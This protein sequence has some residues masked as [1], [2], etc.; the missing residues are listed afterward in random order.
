ML[1]MFTPGEV[2]V[3]TGLSTGMQLDWRKRGYLPV[4]KGRHA[5]FNAFDI[6]RLMVMKM[7]SDRGVG[8]ADTRL[9]ADICAT[10]ILYAALCERTAYR[11]D[12]DLQELKAQRTDLQ[13]ISRRVIHD[14]TG[15]GLVPA[16][17]FIWWADG[18]H[19][20]AASVDSALFH[21]VD[22]DCRKCGPIMLLD[23]NAL[24]RGLASKAGQPLVR[25]DD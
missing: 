18:S 16:Q 7:F 2:E 10:G 19:T 4:T 25:L 15:V 9:I 5:R 6:A 8:P 3:I 11:S 14:I 23:L 13:S 22:D 12:L 20:W 17:Y 21:L 1:E 24:G